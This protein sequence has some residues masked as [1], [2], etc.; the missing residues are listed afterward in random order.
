MDCKIMSCLMM[1]LSGI[2]Q[3]THLILVATIQTKEKIRNFIQLKEG[4]QLVIRASIQ[5]SAN[6]V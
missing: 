3:T 1:P 4:C 6:V 5:K 2:Y